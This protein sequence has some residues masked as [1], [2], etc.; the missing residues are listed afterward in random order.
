MQVVYVDD[1]LDDTESE[2]GD[3]EDNIS[4]AVI[5]DSDCGS[6]DHTATSAKSPSTKPKGM[7]LLFNCQIKLKLFLFIHRQLKLNQILD[8]YDDDVVFHYRQVIMRNVKKLK[9]IINC[10]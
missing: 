4:D 9:H 3:E 10:C 5:S 8:D 7:A 2:F 1:V 6:A